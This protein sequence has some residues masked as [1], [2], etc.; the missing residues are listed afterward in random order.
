MR[1]FKLYNS[2]PLV[3]ALLDYKG[4][5][6]S[7]VKTPCPAFPSSNAPVLYDEGRWIVGLYPI[8]GYLDRR[9]LLPAFFPTDADDYA[10]ACMAFDHFLQQPP[11]P[12]D[13]LPIVAKSN[14]V[15]GDTP[16]IVDLLL[17]QQPSNDPLWLKYQD[18]VRE[19]HG[20]RR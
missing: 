20:G 19:A 1:S 5:D 10:K 16:C 12:S 8:L 15:L 11:H 13:W 7:V 2:N 17:S 18:R 4:V 3:K 9:V 6:Y 14:F